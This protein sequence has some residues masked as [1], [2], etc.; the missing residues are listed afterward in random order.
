[1][2]GKEQQGMRT[3]RKTGKTLSENDVKA[4]VEYL[5]SL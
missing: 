3:M 1:V 4:L 2:E 5:A